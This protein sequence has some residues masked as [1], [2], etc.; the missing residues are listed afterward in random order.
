MEEFEQLTFLEFIE[1]ALA[2][3]YFVSHPT[4]GAP[5]IIPAIFVPGRAPLLLITGPNAGGKSFFRRILNAVCAREKIE[6]MGI[7]MEMRTRGGIQAAFVFG[8]EEWESTGRLS[9]GTVLTGINTCR[10]RDKAHIVCWDEPDLGLSDGYAAGMGRTLAEFISKLPEHTAGA[11]V[12]THSRRLVSGLAHLE[13]HYLHLG[14]ADG[15]ATLQKWLAFEEPIRDIA[16]LP[17][18]Q[19]SRFQAVSK[20]LDE[21][22]AKNRE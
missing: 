14:D 16:E 12:T 2:Q 3:R 17:E 21:Q 5:P 15:P 20:A 1:D 6:F 18:V 7:S 10:K 22:K 11:V 9:A 8:S 19:R 4:T 13:P